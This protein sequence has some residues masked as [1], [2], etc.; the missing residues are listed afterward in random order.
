MNL[1]AD[2]LRM[3]LE[4]LKFYWNMVLVIVNSKYKHDLKSTGTY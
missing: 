3:I 2:E 1:L 4:I